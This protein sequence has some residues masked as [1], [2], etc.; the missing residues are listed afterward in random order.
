MAVWHKP[1]GIEGSAQACI[2]KNLYGFRH[3]IWS[4]GPCW[5]R[6]G[7][8]WSDYGFIQPELGRGEELT[9]SSYERGEGGYETLGVVV[10]VFH[11]FCPC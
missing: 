4:V 11:M 6:V 10:D 5:S 9:F 2:L 7:K 3:G 8:C 1:R